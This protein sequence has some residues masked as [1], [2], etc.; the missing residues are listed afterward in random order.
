MPRSGCFI[1][2]V[3]VGFLLD[4][5]FKVGSVSSFKNLVD[6]FVCSSGRVMEVMPSPEKSL[7]PGLLSNRL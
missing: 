2:P 3:L 5:R 4:A 1:L 6:H 7:I